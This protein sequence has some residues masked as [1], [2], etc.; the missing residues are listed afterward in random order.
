[1][2]NENIIEEYLKKSSDPRSGIKAINI[3]ENNAV[4]NGVSNKPIKTHVAL[5]YF[6]NSDKKIFSGHIINEA[7]NASGEDSAIV[8]TDCRKKDKIK[9]LIA[10]ESELIKLKRKTK[11]N[12]EELFILYWEYGSHSFLTLGFKGL[13]DDYLILNSIFGDDDSTQQSNR[14]IV[15]S[16]LPDHEAKLFNNLLSKHFSM[17]IG[18]NDA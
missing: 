9:I 13:T 7:L 12:S 2:T 11:F 5:L 1:M 14:F 16:L 6:K 8:I 18:E 4:V 17:K 3:A 15:Q 10:T